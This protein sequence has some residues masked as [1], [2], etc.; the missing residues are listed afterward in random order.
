[1]ARQ[2]KAT[3]AVREHIYTKIA[4]MAPSGGGKTYSALRLAKGMA[5]EI[6]HLTGKKARILMANTE[7][8]R[9]KYYANEFDYDIIDLEAPYNPELFIDAINYAVEEKYDIFIMDSTSPEW[10]GPG[11]CLELQQKAGG[12]YQDWKTVTPRHDRFINAL[13]T[14]PIHILA[15]MRGRDQYEVEKDDRGRTSVKKIGVG[16]KQRDGFEYE[17]TCTFI[18]DQKTHTADVQKDNTHIF[19]NDPAMVLTESHGERIIKWANESDVDPVR[20]KFEAEKAK[21]DLDELKKEVITL[22]TPLMKTKKE[23]A[24]KVIAMAPESNPNKI[25]DAET[26]QK[27][28]A[29]LKEL[30]E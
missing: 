13:A 30:E 11:G 23:E 14:S 25:A 2:F 29:A 5:D 8:A 20:E 19:E 3:K 21:V 16:A 24:M 10:D 17:F 22:A 9:G 26:A 7:G 1:M 27:I 12:K 6:E 4:L 28:I 15:T 18:V